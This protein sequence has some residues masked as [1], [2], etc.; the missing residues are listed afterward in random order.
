[1]NLRLLHAG[2]YLTTYYDSH[3]DWLYADWH[4]ELTLPAVQA[5]SL[6]FARC[7]LHRSYPRVLNSNALVTSVS[8]D[9]TP[10]LAQELLPAMEF[11][12]M[13]EVAWVCAPALRGRHMAQEIANRLPHMSLTLFS[14]LE[15]AV[16]WLQRSCS[17]YSSGC[18]RPP[19]LPAI[20]TKLET[21]FQRLTQHV[22][23]QRL[24]TL[25][26]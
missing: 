12:G 16:A 3:N 7:Y 1:M 18:G 2:P 6:D 9:V 26:C 17:E 15:E 13:Q 5:A 20:Q 8:W 4:G 11:T 21:A 23:T 25:L 22:D 10:W 24:A 14:D 19:R